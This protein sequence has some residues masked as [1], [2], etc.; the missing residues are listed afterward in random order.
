MVN[1]EKKNS[2]KVLI[3][4]KRRRNKNQRKLCAT[5]NEASIEIQRLLRSGNCVDQSHCRTKIQSN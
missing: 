2:S 5:K 3:K 1:Y 4:N